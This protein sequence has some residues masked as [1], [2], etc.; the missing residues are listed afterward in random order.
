MS[1]GRSDNGTKPRRRSVVRLVL[2]CFLLGLVVGTTGTIILPGLLRPYLPEALDREGRPFPGE[3][4][5]KRAEADRLILTVSTAEGTIFATFK[6]RV[7]EIELL[8][9]EGDSITLEL[10]EY[11]PFVDD[12][13][14]AR[15]LSF[16]APARNDTLQ[17]A[18]SAATRPDTGTALPDTAIT[19][20]PP[21]A[22]ESGEGLAPDHRIDVFPTRHS[23]ISNCRPS[24]PS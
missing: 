4:S 1:D 3:V 22:K 18:D 13:T 14:I 20:K 9:Q 12:P 24:S 15:V 2:L 7:A 17:A 23:R 21:L 8:I 16:S 19:R 6:D 10:R 11:T 5:T